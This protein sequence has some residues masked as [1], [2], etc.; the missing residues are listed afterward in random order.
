VLGRL[1]PNYFLAGEILLGLKEAEEAIRADVANPLGL[2]V[3]KAAQGITR[4]ADTN[5]AQAVQVMTV[6]RGYDPRDF[7]LVAYGGAGP[8]HAVSVAKEL[9]IKK[10]IVP[11]LPGQFSAFGMLLTDLKREYVLSH[12]KP[13]S[14]INPEAL[15]TMYGNLEQ[16]GCE[17][18]TQE[19][20]S[21]KDLIVQRGAEMR[22]SGQEF[23]LVVSSVKT[24]VTAA[25]LSELKSRFDQVYQVRYGHAFPE[26]EAELVSLRLEVYGVLPK[27]DIGKMTLY[28]KRERE[29]SV[30]ER[31]VNFF[32][33]GFTPS[34][35]Y[36]R[37]S[38]TPGMKVIGPA[39][40][41]EPASTTVL[42]PGGVAMADPSGNL[43]I[44]VSI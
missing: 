34:K 26:T 41:E 30:G 5:M 28:E 35:V 17:E 6:E 20:F 40:I 23:T 22:Y 27:P 31:A 21:E 42:Y 18:F 10:V 4:I 11:Q 8:S 25:A 43:I 36:R 3:V 9:G 32:E 7:V 29:A 39:I 38:L 37:G 13:L 15:E 44:D 1:N 14:E 19:G 16:E 12:V 2:D 33:G 24:P